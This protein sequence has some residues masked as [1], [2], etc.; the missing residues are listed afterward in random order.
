MSKDKKPLEEEKTV[1]YDPVVVL[2]AAL[3]SAGESGDV[4]F[5]GYAMST[6]WIRQ[7]LEAFE[8][9]GMKARHHKRS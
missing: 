9:T 7:T 4:L 3:A 8:A 5:G 6:Y 1:E 2:K